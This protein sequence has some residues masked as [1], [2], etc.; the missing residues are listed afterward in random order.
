[1]RLLSALSLAATFLF[2][3]VQNVAANELAGEVV[4]S[5]L[6]KYGTL[7]NT[8]EKVDELTEMEKSALRDYLTQ[9]EYKRLSDLNNNQEQLEQLKVQQEKEILLNQKR[10]QSGSRHDH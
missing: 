8:L 6:K 5:I 4:Q 10:I 1:M 2:L 3:P 9:M 7:E